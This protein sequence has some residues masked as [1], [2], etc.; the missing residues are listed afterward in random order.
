MPPGGGSDPCP[1]QPWTVPPSQW[2]GAAVAPGRL[3]SVTPPCSLL[4]H[5][6]TVSEADPRG[7]V[8]GPVFTRRR[9]GLSRGPRQWVRTLGDGVSCLGPLPVCQV[10][11]H[12]VPLKVVSSSPWRPSTFPTSLGPSAFLFMSSAPFSVRP[13]FSNSFLFLAGVGVDGQIEEWRW[14]GGWVGGWTDG[15]TDGQVGGCLGGWMDVWMDGR[16]DG[17]TGRWMD[18]RVDG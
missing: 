3:P 6:G 11:Q 8:V 12:Q 17:W 18:G 2:P 1:H 13:S 10:E 15:R 16:T 4:G 7:G 9:P 5:E 14:V